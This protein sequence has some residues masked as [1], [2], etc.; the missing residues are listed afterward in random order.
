MVKK[1]ADLVS[2]R[3]TRILKNKNLRNSFQVDLKTELSKV[4]NDKVLAQDDSTAFDV[5]NKAFLSVVNDYAPLTQSTNKYK[6]LPNWFNNKQKHA[7]WMKDKS[8]FRA[9][10]KFKDAR[11]QFEKNFRLTKA[12]F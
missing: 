10:E 11:M 9:K 1:T 7:D 2:F 5:F 12:M 4:D 8:N 3:D 6:N